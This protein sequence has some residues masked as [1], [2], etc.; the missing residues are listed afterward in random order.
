MIYIQE[1]DSALM[2]AVKRGLTVI[3]KELMKGGADKN[4][5]NNVCQ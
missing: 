2:M 4:L 3:A 5:Q 1:G